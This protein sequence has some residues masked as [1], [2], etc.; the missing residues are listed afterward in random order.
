MDLVSVL[1]LEDTLLSSSIIIPTQEQIWKRHSDLVL[2]AAFISF[3]F[4]L[5]ILAV[6]GE[7]AK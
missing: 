4:L 2:K 7:K 5:L 1:C 6:G 3:S